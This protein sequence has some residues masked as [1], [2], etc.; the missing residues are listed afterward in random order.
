P[1]MPALAAR[2]EAFLNQELTWE[3]IAQPLTGHEITKFKALFN[4]ID[5]KNIEAMIEASKEDAAAEM[6]AKEKA[7]AAKTETEL[8]KDPIADEIEFDTFAQVDLRIARIIS[9]EEVP[10]ANKLLKFQLDIG[11]ETRQV[12]SG[13]KSAYKPEELEGKLTVMVANLK[14][15]KMKFGMSEGMILA[16]GPGGSDLWIL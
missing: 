11:G 1:V 14:P 7:E 3:G 12:F 6:A 9:C 10:K 2:T 5:P 8:S 16:A 4:R 13:I 15:R